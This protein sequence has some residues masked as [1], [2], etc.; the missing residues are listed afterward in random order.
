[1]NLNLQGQAV[2]RVCFDSALTVLTSGDYELR[3]ETE[4]VLQV[5]SGDHVSFD[6]ESPDVV[7]PYLVRLA[8]DVITGAEVGRVGD[9]VIEFESG[10]NLIVRPDDDYEAWGLVGPKGRRV[11]CM[12]GGEIAVWSGE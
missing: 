12:P 5:S 6:P 9:L 7:A 10:T 8:R 2:T 1:M 4:A 11:T 3:V